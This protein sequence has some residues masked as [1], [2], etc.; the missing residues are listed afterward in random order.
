[1]MMLLVIV[2]VLI[3]MMLLVMVTMI[4]KLSP[5]SWFPAPP[6]KL[7]TCPGRRGAEMIK[8]II[9]MIDHDPNNHDELIVKIHDDYENNSQGLN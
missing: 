4:V 7:G 9:K 8:M 2:T 6:C 3:M 5:H 1:M